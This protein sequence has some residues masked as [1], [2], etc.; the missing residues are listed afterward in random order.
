MKCFINGKRT[1]IVYTAVNMPPYN[2]FIDVIHSLTCYP[3]F[4]IHH[5]DRAKLS[6]ISV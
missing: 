1:E 6:D 5:G 3:V 2:G 4:G